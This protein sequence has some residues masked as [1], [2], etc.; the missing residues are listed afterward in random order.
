MGRPRI[1]ETVVSEI[2]DLY[3][4]IRSR[5]LRRYTG[6]IKVTRDLLRLVTER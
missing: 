5:Q 2:E 3:F 4:E 6:R 1:P